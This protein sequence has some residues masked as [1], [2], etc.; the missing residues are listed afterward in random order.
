MMPSTKGTV[1]FYNRATWTQGEESTPSPDNGE[2]WKSDQKAE[3]YG[4]QT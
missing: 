1:V 4:S 3:D 2:M